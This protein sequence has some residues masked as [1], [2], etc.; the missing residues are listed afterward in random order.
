VEADDT[1]VVEQKLL[2]Y[3]KTHEVTYEGMASEIV[4]LKACW[5]DPF[6]ADVDAAQAI[7]EELVVD[8]EELK[9]NEMRPIT[10]RTQQQGTNEFGEPITVRVNVKTTEGHYFNL[11]ELKEKLESKVEKTAVGQQVTKDQDKDT[12]LPQV[13][14]K[15]YWGWFDYD[16]DDIAEECVITLAQPDTSSIIIRCEPSAYPSRPYIITRYIPIEGQ[17]YGL[18]VLGI[19]SNMQKAIND[20]QNQ[21][22]DD[23]TMALLPMYLLDADSELEDKDCVYGQSKVLRVEDTEKELVP[24]RTSILLRNAWEALGIVKETQRQA[25]GASRTLA[26]TSMPYHTTATEISSQTS[27]ANARIVFSAIVFEEEYVVP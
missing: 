12:P 22:I 20:M 23:V 8:F 4:D 1:L 17:T 13:K 7:V 26:A 10:K 9:R 16:G 15:T 3:K 18:G 24:M 25:T 19:M 27:E 14:I 21:A 2:G 11:K 5:L 6:T